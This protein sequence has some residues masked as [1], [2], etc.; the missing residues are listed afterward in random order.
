MV[1]KG[2]KPPMLENQLWFTE[3]LGMK[4]IIPEL[5]KVLLGLLMKLKILKKKFPGSNKLYSFMLK[6]CNSKN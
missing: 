5:G 2:D 6:A 1:G 3:A 4:N